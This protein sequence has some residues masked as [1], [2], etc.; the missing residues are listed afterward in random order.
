MI[1][2]LLFLAILYLK[3]DSLK[4]I[5]KKSEI[6]D[7]LKEVIEI[8]Q[9]NGKRI[10]QKELR[11]KLPYSEA[12]TSLIIADLESRKLIRKIKRGRGNIIFLKN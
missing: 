1:L 6:P 7:D 11:E 9:K 3:K 4:K 10:S 5:L 2:I 12:K 8:I